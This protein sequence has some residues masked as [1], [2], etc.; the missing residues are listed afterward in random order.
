MTWRTGL[1]RGCDT[2]LRP[3]GRAADGPHEAQEARVATR[4]HADAREGRHMASGEV[5]IWRAHGLVGLVR[6]LG[7]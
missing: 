1:A 4:V 2:T 6:S 3:R 5:D 7:G